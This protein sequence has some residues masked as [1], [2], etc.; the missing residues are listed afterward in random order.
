M[1]PVLL[2]VRDFEIRGPTTDTGRVLN[3]PVLIKYSNPRRSEST[4]RRERPYNYSRTGIIC[5]G[6]LAMPSLL[7]RIL[8]SYCT[9]RLPTARYRYRSLIQEGNDLL[10]QG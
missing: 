2:C 10:L 5:I 4:V 3:V 7:R 6:I 8:Y 1:N 9:V